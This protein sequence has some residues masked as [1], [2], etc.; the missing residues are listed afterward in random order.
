MCCSDLDMYSYNVINSC[1]VE[2]KQLGS[3]GEDEL[4]KDSPHHSVQS[5]EP[6]DH[7]ST[8][9]TMNEQNGGGDN[10]GNKDQNTDGG[11]DKD[12]GT[13]GLPPT[14]SIASEQEATDSNMDEGVD[15]GL[16][17]SLGDGRG[18]DATSSKG[19]DEST[20]PAQGSY[21]TSHV[22]CMFEYGIVTIRSH[23]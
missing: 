15:E 2:S 7:E 5:S 19:Y 13:G 12:G 14:S 20:E 10:V 3:D 23:C 4:D 21:V 1:T 16:P 18:N 6:Q 22:T 17:D 8:K 11:R 9:D